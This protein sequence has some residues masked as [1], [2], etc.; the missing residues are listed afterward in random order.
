MSTQDYL[1]QLL[2][3]GTQ[4]ESAD[5]CLCKKQFA[6]CCSPQDVIVMLLPNSRLCVHGSHQSL[7]LF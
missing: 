5:E 3:A 7:Y 2:S 1:L 4:T 6:V